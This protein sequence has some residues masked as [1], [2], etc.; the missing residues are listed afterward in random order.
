MEI[1]K[2]DILTAPSLHAGVRQGMQTEDHWYNDMTAVKETSSWED[3]EKT[4][5]RMRMRRMR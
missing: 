1:C 4:E 2:C 5:T 3:E